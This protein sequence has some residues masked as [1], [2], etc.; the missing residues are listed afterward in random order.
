M[1][2]AEGTWGG[3]RRRGQL[4]IPAFLLSWPLWF[5]EA[6]EVNEGDPQG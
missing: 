4:L 1:E 6:C 3:A 5:L 2:E